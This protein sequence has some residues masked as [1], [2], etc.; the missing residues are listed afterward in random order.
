MSTQ[1]HYSDLS[2][3]DPR[4]SGSGTVHTHAD[5]QEYEA[6]VRNASEDALTNNAK[7]EVIVHD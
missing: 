6:A 2:Q 7:Q 3:H 4:L 1:K 5:L